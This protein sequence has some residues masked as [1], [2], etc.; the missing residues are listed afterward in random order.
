MSGIFRHEKYEGN[1]LGIVIQNNDPEK[2][3]R[4]KV[5][6]PHISVTVYEEWSKDKKDK[7]FRFLDAEKNPDLEKILPYLK[8]VLPWAEVA[9]P[10]FGGS[11][12]GR[13]NAYLKK[14]TTSDSNYWE[15][16]TLVEGFR[17]LQNYINEN[18]VSDAFTRTDGRGGR[19]VNPFAAEYSPSDYSNLARG[20][21]SS[22]NVGAHVWVFFTN[23][24]SGFPV[25]F[26]ISHGQED[27]K[28]IYSM[29][30]KTNQDDKK[31]VSEDYPSSF[32]NLAPEEGK[33]LD[34]NVKTFRSKHVWNSNKHSI[35]LIDTD[36]KEILKMTHYS[37]SFFEI[38]NSTITTFATNNDQKLVLGDQF[39]TVRRN[40]AIYIANYQENNIQGDRITNLG[41]FRKRG[42]LAGQILEIL[43]DTHEWKRL[44]E[45][46]RT[47][48]NPPYTSSLQ[49]L[50]GAP[51]V[52]PV[53]Q[54]AGV[55]FGLPCVTC[56]GKGISP[57][58]QWGNYALE[59]K[60]WPPDPIIEKICINQ[61]RIIDLELEAGFKNGGDDISHITG[62]IVLTVGTV[63]NDLE[64][65]R[66]DPIGK[67]RNSEAHVGKAGTYIAMHEVPLVE[68]VDVDSVPGGDYD[69]T[70]GNKYRLNV[71]SKG[72]HIKTTGP[73]DIYGTIVNLTGESVNISSD[74][75]VIVDG[76]KRLELR[77]DV[78]N[79][80]P[81]KSAREF[82]NLDGNVGVRNNLIVVGG[83]HIEG[84]LTYLHQTAPKML[85]QTEIGFGPVAHTHNFYGPPWALLDSCEDVRQ[86]A[87]PVNRQTPTPNMKCPG[88]WV[89]S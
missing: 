3:G 63:F 74:W 28:R 54:G 9:C 60:K 15:G 23:G 22:I 62:N 50:A 78:I 67:I 45:T 46:M 35:E 59:A 52:C 44:F 14:G 76:G 11:S 88:F 16:D 21:F 42:I 36:K 69:I 34:H 85:Y 32:E 29:S 13:Y 49:T 81:K 43:R 84:E 5:F 58:T 37:G 10:I 47:A 40:Q 30:K 89:P 72:I 24:N 87:Q 48:S 8:R 6:I 7:N 64:S 68:Y 18:K 75:E 12:S 39:L 4:V 55:K 26:A 77:A 38:N 82:I 56:G 20:F 31:F 1:Y 65:Y 53:C 71:G 2:R 80:K 70:V 33:E 19:F 66:V 86:S 61:K 57:S 83:A 51:D 27:W 41:D 73:L 17:P 25:V 79:I